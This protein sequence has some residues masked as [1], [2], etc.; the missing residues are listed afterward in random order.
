M[1]IK[2]HPQGVVL[3]SDITPQ[4]VYAS[5]RAFIA[6]MAL[7]AVAGGALWEMANREAFDQ[8]P[9]QKLAARPK[10]VFSAH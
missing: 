10:P 3:P 1:L 9:G 6:K 2:R 8:E 4:E 7:G 5:R